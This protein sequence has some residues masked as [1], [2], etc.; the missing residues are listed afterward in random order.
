[1]NAQ[2]TPPIEWHP[3]ASREHRRYLLTEAVREGNAAWLHWLIT[4]HRR[5]FRSDVVD[6]TAAIEQAGRPHREVMAEYT[7]WL[8]TEAEQARVV[9]PDD[10]DRVSIRIGQA[11]L[12]SL[13]ELLADQAVTS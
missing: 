13:H 11:P 12:F 6:V 9:D 5:C 10:I 2:L 7:A 4:T 1:M 8:A 3:P